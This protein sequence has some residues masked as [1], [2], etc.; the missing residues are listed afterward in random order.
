MLDVAPNTPSTLGKTMKVDIPFVCTTHAR[1]ELAL[2]YKDKSEPINSKDFLWCVDGLN[3]KGLTVAVLYQSHS[4][5]EWHMP[6]VTPCTS[7]SRQVE[8]AAQDV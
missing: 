8:A 2:L 6:T 3:M 1:A 5:G 4:T 7:V